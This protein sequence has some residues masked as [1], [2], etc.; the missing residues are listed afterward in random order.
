VTVVV[1]L[2]CTLLLLCGAATAGARGI[3]LGDAQATYDAWPAARVLVDSDNSLDW[4]TAI[5]RLDRFELPRVPHANLG[6][7]RTP[8]WLHLEVEVAPDERSRWM[9]DID[10]PSLDRVDVFVV[11]QGRLKQRVV[12]GDTVA[13]APGAVHTRSPAVVLDLVPGIRYDLLL[14]VE[15]TSSTILPLTLRA[16]QRFHASEARVQAHQGLM[17]GLG[18]CLLMYSLVHWTKQRDDLYLYYGL[19]ALATTLFFLAY[20]G[21]GPQHLWPGNVWMT[22]HVGPL[23]VLGA[24]AGAF[25]F[26]RHALNTDEIWRPLSRALVAG[27]WTALA[28]ASA[29]LFDLIDYRAAHLVATVLGPLPMLLGLPAAWMRLRRGDRTAGFMLVGWV[30]YTLT[31]VVLIGLLRGWLPSNFWTQHAFQFGSMFEMV[32]WQFVLAHRA[33]SFRLVAVRAQG[34]RDAYEALAQTDPLTGLYNR[35]GL[36]ARIGERLALINAPDRQLAVF[37]VDLDG[38]KAVNDSLGH[39]A[40]DALLR[41]VGQRLSAQLRSTDVIARLGGDEF[42]VVSEPLTGDADAHRLGLKLLAGFD[43]PF[44]IDGS[45]IRIGLTI[46]YAL[47]PADGSGADAL[48]KRADAAMYDGKRNGRHCVRRFGDPSARAVAP[49]E[50]AV[51]N[52]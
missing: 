14:R 52:A 50:R 21:L 3:V 23:V 20:F 8:V 9:L 27:Y 36:T 16:E 28:C 22:V 47:A 33:E 40:G 24:L 4:T 43:P 25:N 5:A 15:T 44:A 31:V 18:L 11:S 38:F 51:V 46:G 6:V 35:R 45:E 34:E 41:A 30:G 7:R 29:F 19:N 17:A 42:V 12:L 10:F 26:M 49:S 32:M 48:L 13:P 37:M 1:R 39:E 2:L